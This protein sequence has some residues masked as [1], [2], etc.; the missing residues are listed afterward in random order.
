MWINASLRPLTQFAADLSGGGQHEPIQLRK[1]GTRAMSGAS[2]QVQF[3]P[4]LLAPGISKANAWTLMLACFI[5]I[6]FLSFV[7]I[8]QAYV[9]NANLGLAGDEQGAL[10]GNLAAFSE[11]VVLLL[12]GWFGVLSDRIGRRPIV[13]AGVLIMA[14]AYVIYPLTSQAWQLFF[15]RGTYAVGIAAMIG[16]MGTLIQDYPD[17]MS[18]GKMLALTGFFNGI[19]VVFVNA[20][21]G[22]LPDVLVDSGVDAL[23]AGR[24][25][26][27]VVAALL[28]PGAFLMARGLKGGTMVRYDERPATRELVWQGLRAARNPRVALAYGSSFVSRSDFVVIG[29]F[30]VLW[31]AVAGIEQGVTPADAVKQGAILIVVAN[32]S[33]MLWMPVMGLLIDRVRRTAALAIGS[34][35]AAGAFGAMWFVDNPLDSSA[36]PWFALLGIGQTS[37]F[38]TSQAL[39]GQEAELQSRGSVIGM[40]GIFGAAGILFATSVGGQ[41]FDAWMPAAPYILIGGANAVIAVLAALV[42]WRRP[43]TA[44]PR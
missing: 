24:Y 20:L 16:M 1:R 42:W 25:A 27:W 12:V 32:G 4:V 28:L 30:S 11:F 8:G 15:M 3:G 34:L 23:A 39:I 18:R 26:H 40:F 43:E 33:A 21:F 5:S 6:G 10:S 14:A 31:A 41:L 7:N 17:E 2:R 22:R 13:V 9:L 35:V 44:A 37:C 29:T 38:L 36:L 19:G